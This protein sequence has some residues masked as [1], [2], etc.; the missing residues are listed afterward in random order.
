LKILCILEIPSP[1]ACVDKSLDFDHPDSSKKFDLQEMELSDKQ[2]NPLTIQEEKKPLLQLNRIMFE[3]NLSL[4]AKS[5]I[6]SFL[7]S[8]SKSR[9]LEEGDFLRR[10]KSFCF[11]DMSIMINQTDLAHLLGMIFDDFRQFSMQLW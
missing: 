6:R 3:D 7:I 1:E 5:I 4:K 2:R 11:G 10:M 8:H 9:F